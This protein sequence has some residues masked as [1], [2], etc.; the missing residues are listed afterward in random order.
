MTRSQNLVV[1]DINQL[2]RKSFLTTPDP[3]CC[4]MLL[5][6]SVV[7]FPVIKVGGHIE[8]RRLVK[9]LSPPNDE[10]EAV[11]SMGTLVLPLGP[12]LYY[13]DTKRG[14]CLSLIQFY[15][16]LYKTNNYQ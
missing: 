7:L 16:A 1:R 15:L 9:P 5:P 2:F 14:Y 13:N 4:R 6:L 3:I 11:L 12:P 10:M 8:G